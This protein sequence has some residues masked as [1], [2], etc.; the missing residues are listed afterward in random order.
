MSKAQESSK[1]VVCDAHGECMDILSALA[2]VQ[3]ERL[4]VSSGQDELAPIVETDT[5]YMSLSL[6]WSS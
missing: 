5:G 2:I 4:I 3:P 1:L 6:R